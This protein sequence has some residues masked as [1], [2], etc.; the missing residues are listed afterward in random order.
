MKDFNKN[1]KIILLIIIIPLLLVG[2][3]FMFSKGIISPLVKGVEIKI[4]GGNYIK[5]LDKY[6]VKQGDEVEISAGNYVKIPGYAKDPELWFNV[7]DD[8]GIAEIK[9]NKMKALKEGYTSVAVMKGSRLIKKAMIK[10]VNPDVDVLDDTGI[11]E[12]KGNK[13]KALKEGYTSVA[14]MKGS[15]LIKKAMIKIVNPDVESLDLDLSESLK[16]V[17]DKATITSSVAISNYKKFEDTYKTKYL[18]SDESVIKI[19]GDNAMAVGVGSA[20]ISGE[21]GGKTVD[22]KKFE[23]TYK[24]KYLSSDES[25]IK[26]DGDNAMAVGVGSATISGECGGKTVEIPLKIEAK[27]AKL[28][29]PKEFVLEEGQTA[30][31]KPKVTTSPKGLKPPKV[32]YKYSTKKKKDER[33]AYVSDGGQI[34]AVREGTENIVVSCGQKSA[35]VKITVKKRSI[36]N[37]SIKNIN[38][39]YNV[40]GNKIKIEISWDSL[41][42]IKAYDIYAKKQDDEEY[43]V[44]K[45][46]PQSEEKEGKVSTT[47]EIELSENDENEEESNEKSL[48]MYIVG[49]GENESTKP[50][51]KIIIKY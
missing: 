14:V 16:Y 33:A 46:I 2:Q 34:S 1:K 30:T 19:D 49:V 41:D 51:E 24:T 11:A 6:I 25:V 35:T 10:I 5:D 37:S 45:T 29:V 28:E 26:I 42:G 43:E 50:S 39:S 18:S 3:Y 36:K 31:I 17:G 23:D 15:R 38:Y 4:I 47:I 20:T 21:C 32:E 7:L 12:I 22:Y 27:I 9:G 13:M 44:L 40:E 8:T 48:D